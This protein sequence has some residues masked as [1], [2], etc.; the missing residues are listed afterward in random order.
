MLGAKSDPNV[1]FA[2]TSLHSSASALN[3]S[4][5]LI[6]ITSNEDL[7][8]AFDEM[9]QKR[10]EA[11]IVVT[12]TLTLSLKTDIADGA[13]KNGLPS[14]YGHKSNV[15]AGGLISLGPDLFQL[16]RQSARLVAKIIGGA[17]PANIP[18]EQ[19]TKFEL[20][21]NMKTAKALGLA[22]P[23]SILAGADE[24]IE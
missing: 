19:P 10:S 22:I 12:G 11:L 20:I 8:A 16:A 13:Q 14:C 4:I 3:T 23:P 5:T 17:L 9:R 21:I 1:P 6:E 15:V 24:V 2:M 7:A 18:V